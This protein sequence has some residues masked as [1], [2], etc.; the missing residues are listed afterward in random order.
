MLVNF[1][2]LFLCVGDIDAALDTATCK[3]Y[4]TGNFLFFIYN[5]NYNILLFFFSLD[6]VFLC[7]FFG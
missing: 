4:I 2:G 3:L 1:N 5:Y 6:S 7:S